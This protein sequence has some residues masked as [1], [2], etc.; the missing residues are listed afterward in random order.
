VSFSRCF[1]SRTTCASS[2]SVSIAKDPKWAGAGQT[3]VQRAL[4]TSRQQRSAAMMAAART[5]GTGAPARLTSVWAGKGGQKQRHPLLP[6][7][8]GRGA[9]TN[10]AGKAKAGKASSGTARPPSLFY[11]RMRR[12]YTLGFCSHVSRI[13]NGSS[14]RPC[15]CGW[16]DRL[17]SKALPGGGTAGR[18]CTFSCSGWLRWVLASAGAWCRHCP[19]GGQ[20]TLPQPMLASWFSSSR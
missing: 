18:W 14:V 1:F 17:H 19:A 20:V 13:R 7:A 5:A 3:G 2:I 10:K 11:G 4:A 9:V 6:P 12:A 8:D 16:P 15:H